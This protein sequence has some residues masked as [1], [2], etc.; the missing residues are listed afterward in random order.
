V[1][2]PD[3]TVLAR[4]SSSKADRP[5][6]RHVKLPGG[7]GPSGGA[8]SAP[9][10]R[11]SSP[12]G[13]GNRAASRGGGCGVGK[14]VSLIASSVGLVPRQARRR[15]S[16]LPQRLSQR[17]QV[18]RNVRACARQPTAC[19]VP[20]QRRGRAALA[21]AGQRCVGPT[22][23]LSGVPSGNGC[24]ARWE[25]HAPARPA[26]SRRRARSGQ[27][28]GG[29][30]LAKRGPRDGGSTVANRDPLA[31]RPRLR[32]TGTGA[33][34]RSPA[35]TRSPV[36]GSPEPEA[37]YP[38]AGSLVCPAGHIGRLRP[39]GR[40]SKY[41]VRPFGEHDRPGGHTL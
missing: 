8:P 27:P 9:P 7:A 5:L 39:R 33:A 36:G 15:R 16:A 22:R 18:S 19:G 21:P 24:A 20:S 12:F 14:D 2:G 11:L 32:P 13:D 37:L 26:S 17:V 34:S 31:G 6:V 38:S 28:K 1:N 29:A 23:R 4:R 3:R 30:A 10:A 35:A 25:A 41:W 40:G